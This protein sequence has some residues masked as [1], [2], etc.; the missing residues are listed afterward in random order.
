MVLEINYLKG[1]TALVTGATRRIGRAVACALAESKVNVVIHHHTAEGKD[2]DDVVA[3]VQGLGVKSWGLQADLSNIDE[4]GSFFEK[5]RDMAGGI[6]F[7]I[8]NASIFVPST[9]STLTMQELNHTLMINAI[10]PLKLSQ[11]FAQQTQEGC[12]VNMLDSRI[13]QYDLNHAAYQLSKNMLYHITEM[14]AIECAPHIRVNGVAPGLILPPEDKD[15][16]FLQK[17]IHRNLLQRS[18][19]MSDITDAVLFLLSNTFITGEILFI[20]GGQNIKGVPYE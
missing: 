9:L 12:I 19:K 3:H 16:A 6:D 18:G 11:H 15:E 2:V 8:N 14:M 17:Q 10:A 4:V 13:K 7:L 1:K 20:D 5:T